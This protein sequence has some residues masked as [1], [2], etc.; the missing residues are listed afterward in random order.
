MKKIEKYLLAINDR[1]ESPGSYIYV[2]RKNRFLI[3]ITDLDLNSTPEAGVIA[4]NLVYIN[5]ESLPEFYELTIIDNIDNATPEKT[6]KELNMAVKWYREYLKWEDGNH[7]AYLRDYSHRTPGLKIIYSEYAKK[8][9]TIYK[10]A[11]HTFDNEPKMDIYLNTLGFTNEDLKEGYI[12]Q[13]PE[14]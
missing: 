10:G 14:K 6:K 13:I 7:S 12:L 8:W 2:T 4:Q 3:E 1:V 11:V 9:L 5:P